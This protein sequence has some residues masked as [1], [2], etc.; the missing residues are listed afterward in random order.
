MIRAYIL[1]DE[2]RACNILRVLIEKHVPE[3]SAVA[4]STSPE[5]AI[6]QVR[7]FRPSLLFLDIK[8]P[9]WSGFDFLNQ[10]GKW[11]FDVIFTTAFDQYAI[12]AIRFSA[13]DYLL[14]PIDVAELKQAVQSHLLRRENNPLQQRMIIGHL[15]D[16]LRQGQPA[17]SN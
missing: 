16:N 4:W 7:D 10:L 5:K 13:L 17:T 15:M 12:R 14:K 1:D 3:I 8:M 11:D 9:H 2:E 6:E